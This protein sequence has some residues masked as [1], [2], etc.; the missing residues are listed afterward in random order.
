MASKRRPPFTRT[1]GERRGVSPPWKL[2]RATLRTLR[3]LVGLA[4]QLADGDKSK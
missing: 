3:K 1:Q 4:K 2:T